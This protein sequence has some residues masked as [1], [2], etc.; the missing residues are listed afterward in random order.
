MILYASESQHR[1]I[2]QSLAIFK[3]GHRD[4]VAVWFQILPDWH[5]TITRCPK[6]KHKA[7]WKWIF[8]STLTCS[9]WVH[10]GLR[11]LEVE[12]PL[13]R[14]LLFNSDSQSF[15]HIGLTEEL[16][17][18]KKQRMPGY[19]LRIIKSESLERWVEKK[20]FIYISFF[21]KKYTFFFFIQVF[22]FSCAAR[23]EFHFTYRNWM[24][25]KRGILTYF[26]LLPISS[27]HFSLLLE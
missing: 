13:D 22:W 10:P 25:T 21:T 26:S 1:L 18:K 5:S 7:V 23:V 14:A 27:L 19:L 17:K 12:S 24:P 3:K 11:C 2:R 9:K 4:S 20:H 16:K 6:A 8:S 15:L